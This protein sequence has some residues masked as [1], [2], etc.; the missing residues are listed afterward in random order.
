VK[1]LLAN[2]DRRTAVLRNQNPIAGRHTHGQALAILVESTGS[3]GEDLALV[4]LLDRGLGEEDAA[5][6]LG[7]GLDALDEHAVQQG[8][9]V[10]D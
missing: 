6:G 8:D 3:D 2:L 4:Q 7:L 10:L 1:L 5:G 9:Q